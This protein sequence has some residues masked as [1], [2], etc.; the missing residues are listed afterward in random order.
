MSAFVD[1]AK[2][3]VKGGDGGNGVVSFFRAKYIPK[4]G[5]DGGDGGRG[6]SVILEVDE[7]LRTLMDFRYQRHFKA[8]RGQHGQGA[9][10]HG[11][12]GEDIILK[13][14][15]GTLVKDEEGN[16]LADLTEIGER[17][18][19]ARG[20]IGGRGNARFATPTRRSPSFAE[21]GEPGE[22][23]WI[24]LE[25]K[26]LAD[27]GLVGFPNAGKSTLISRIS[28]ARPKIAGYP[29]TTIMPN[30]GV[31]SLPDGRSFVVADIP[32]LIE[33]AHVGKGL[34]YDFLKHIERTAVIVHVLDLAGLEGRDPVEDFE[35][36]NREL[37]LYNP[38]LAARPQV[39]AGNKIDIPEAQHNLPRVE[40]Y[41]TQRDIPFHPISAAVG[42]GV[43]RLLYTVADMLDKVER[44]PAAGKVKQ[45]VLE[46]PKPEEITVSREDEVWVVRGTNVERMVAM[47]DF[48]NEYAVIHLQK[49]LKSIGVEDKLLEA[50]AKEGDT[51]R[52]GKMEFEFYPF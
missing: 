29:F 1:E 33:G 35:T 36:I 17:A 27:V 10:K 30:L 4:G 38:E 50:G 14:P 40:E 26:L 16:I 32:G 19:I 52:I 46:K 9:N 2:I 6:G 23:R 12:N 39:V 42:T 21:K 7:G 3:F 24:T 51:V 13:V 34:G 28:A 15:L 41:M 49:R 11:A 31:V 20:G 22:E 18:V 25:L 37:R 8:K 47:T 45:A 5:P 43:D 44:V 48:E